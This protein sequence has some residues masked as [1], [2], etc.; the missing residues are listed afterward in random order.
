MKITL[1]KSNLDYKQEYTIV[2][3]S[4]TCFLKKFNGSNSKWTSIY[5]CP[6]EH[7]IRYDRK[8]IADICAC[9]VGGEVVDMKNPIKFEAGRSYLQLNG[10]AFHIHECQDEYEGYE[11][12]CD[13][14]K[15]HRYNRSTS[16][17]C[18]GRATGS[19]RGPISLRYP[20]VEYH[21]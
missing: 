2:N 16:A 1:I 9:I 3:R 15:K 21:L 10:D 5:E 4:H 17:W 19:K 6:V 8:W 7:A 11:T 20:P 12:F 14:Y 18:N 13:I